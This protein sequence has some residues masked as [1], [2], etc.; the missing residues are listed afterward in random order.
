MRTSDFFRPELTELNRLTAR[1][2]LEPYDDAASA[3][4]GEIS[5]WRRSLDGAWRFSLA[6]NPDDVPAR[7][8]SPATDDSRWRSIQVPGCWTRQD[9]GDLPVYTNVQMP[10]PELE[11]PQ[12]PDHNPTAVYRTDFSVPRVWRRRD[13]VLHL[14]A[15]ESMAVV[16]C[17]GELVGMGKDSRLPS[18]FDLTPHLVAGRNLLAVVVTRYCDA[19]WIED[20]DHWWHAGIHRSV[21]LEARSRDRIDNLTIDADYDAGGGSG[22]LDVRADVVGARAAAVRVSVETLGGRTVGRPTTVSVDRP[23]DDDATAAYLYTLIG[24]G[25][26]ADIRIELDSV[27]PWSAE[28]PTRYRVITELLDSANEP[29]EAHATLTGFRRIEVAGRR[30]KVNGRPIM[31]HGVNRHD[32]HPVTGKTVSVEEMREE[33]VLMK[34]HNINAVRTSH[35]P[36]DHRLLD[37]TDELGL[38][39][40]DEANCEAHAR[41]AVISRHPGF[42][43]AIFE[44]TRRMVRRDRNHPSIIIW[45]LGNEAGNGDAFDGTAA[46]LKRVDTSR[47]VQYEGILRDRFYPMIATR[48]RQETPDPSERLVTDVLCPMYEPIAS[49]TAWAEWAE[50]TELDDRPMILCEFSHAM[51]NS[52]GS[53]DDYVA[54]FYA[55]PALAGGFIWD[56]RDQGLAETDGAGRPYWAYG[57]HFGEPVHDA[58]FNING[59]VGPDLLPHPGLTEYQWA[60]RPTTVEPVKGR[61]V[62]ITNRRIFTSTADLHLDWELLVNGTRVEHGRLVVDL[63]PGGSRV[64]TVPAQHRKKAGEEAHLTFRWTTRRATA[65]VPRGH[66]VSWDQVMMTA[67]S[68]P[69]RQPA[70]PGRLRVEVGDDGIDGIWRGDESLVLGDITPTLWRAPID[71]ERGVSHHW[72]AQG[73]PDPEMTIEQVSRSRDG[74]ALTIR[75]RLSYRDAEVVHTTRVAVGD[76]IDFDERIDIPESFRDLPR[77]GMRFEVP[78]ELE[79]LEWFGLGPHETY[80]DRKSSGLIGRWR[81]TVAE[82]YHPFA[83]PQEHGAHDD[84]R[85]FSLVDDRRRGI[86]VAAAEPFLFSARQHHDH[87]L[88]R[89]DTLATLEASST[90]EVHVDRAVRGLGTGACGPDTL[91]AYKVRPGRHRWHWSIGAASNRSTR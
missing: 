69:A 54:A 47:P 90:T 65:S 73:L 32:H 53:L 10:W 25:P 33:L 56:W 8:T 43:N 39:V 68:E 85:W 64:V 81:S 27:H 46:W 24:T 77:I 38:Y 60:I 84:C 76:V 80:P 11:P 21:H 20:Q 51:G 9:T 34:Q 66:L 58:N 30:L 15:V 48:G 82:Q 55:Q 35:Y 88:A 62:R 16:Y 26:G 57:G 18:E 13:V 40:V 28:D 50:R 44:R 67:R 29:I 6:D 22:S 31:I 12:T 83:V 86:M 79:R 61:R 87:D 17:N 41:P 89:A 36:N 52:N 2:P 37:L 74:N 7:W 19:S 71:N 3:R 23:V 42:T 5:P 1:P 14:G 49:M 63:E 45:S 91:P 72:I 70:Q 78:V 75:R 4:V 59:L